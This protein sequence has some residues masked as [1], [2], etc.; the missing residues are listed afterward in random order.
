MPTVGSASAPQHWHAFEWVPAGAGAGDV[1]EVGPVR[2]GGVQHADSDAV[3]DGWD[4]EVEGHFEQSDQDA[5][6]EGS[7]EQAQAFAPGALDGEVDRAEEERRVVG[8]QP[9]P[10]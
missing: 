8:S 10:L 7:G 3:G 6:D 4:G 9:D 2:G 1:Q 5:R